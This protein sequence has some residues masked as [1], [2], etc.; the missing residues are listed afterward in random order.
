MKEGPGTKIDKS[1][2]LT[3][4]ITERK[5]KEGSRTKIDKSLHLTFLKIFFVLTSLYFSTLGAEEFGTIVERRWE[6]MRSKPSNP[7]QTWLILQPS[8]N[9][10]EDTRDF[11]KVNLVREII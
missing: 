4:L 7:E 10:W 3:A 6:E 11:N 8:K 1:L 2:D 9:S 5:I